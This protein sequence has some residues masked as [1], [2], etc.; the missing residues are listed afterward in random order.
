MLETERA[1]L[2]TRGQIALYG[3]NAENLEA[4]VKRLEGLSSLC[5]LV[6]A[7]QSHDGSVTNSLGSLTPEAGDLDGQGPESLGYPLPRVRL[8]RQDRDVSLTCLD[9]SV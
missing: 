5:G 6:E 3:L 7:P 9:P 4:E 2:L 8:C 1:V